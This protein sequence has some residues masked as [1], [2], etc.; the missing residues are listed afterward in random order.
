MSDT[1]SIGSSGMRMC[2]R[3]RSR[4]GIPALL[5]LALLAC[6]SSI[7]RV[8]AYLP[9]G[10]ARGGDAAVRWCFDPRGRWSS[11]AP[12]TLCCPRMRSSFLAEGFSLRARAKRE[13]QSRVGRWRAEENTIIVS[14]E[15]RSA[16][17]RRHLCFICEVILVFLLFVVPSARGRAGHE[18][19]RRDPSDC[20][21]TGHGSRLSSA[22]VNSSPRAF[23]SCSSSQRSL[24]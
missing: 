18:V 10:A 21:K 5:C 11:A 24:R 19:T 3:P 14:E 6:S 2:A 16:Q 12:C 9:A 8:L 22:S 23:G 1:L 20:V 15:V 17:V 4:R 13:G 7:I